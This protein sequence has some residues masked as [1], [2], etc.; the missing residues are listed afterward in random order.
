MNFLCLIDDFTRKFAI[1]SHRYS[2]LGSLSVALVV[3]IGYKP[4]CLNN[5]SRMMS[6]C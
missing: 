6:N 5:K 2:R 1:L 4:C 3:K